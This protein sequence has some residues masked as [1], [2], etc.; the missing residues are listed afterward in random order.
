VIVDFHAHILPRADH[1]SDGME[2]TLRQLSLI[3]RGGTDAV[4]ATPHFYPE[5][6]LVESF[7]RRRADALAE[8]AKG[9]G[10]ADLPLLFCGAEVL[11]CPGIEEMASLEK[12]CIEGTG[13]ILLELPFSGIGTDVI[14][15][16]LAV[17][18]LGLSPVLA[19][20]DRYPDDRIGILLREGIHAQLNAEGFRGLL[21]GRRYRKY[22]ENGSVVALGSDLHGV[23]RNGYADFLRM[24]KRLGTLADTVFERTQALLSQATPADLTHATATVS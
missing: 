3:K 9:K 13:I 17:R 10:E 15:S 2:T 19:H 14:D 1:G 16:V 6:H 22:I 11:V 12:L 8:L 23:P 18:D 24:R 5:R 4:V 20:I 21:S 7:L